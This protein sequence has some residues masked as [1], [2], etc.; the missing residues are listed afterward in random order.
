MTSSS[1]VSDLESTPTAR[2]E[3][4]NFGASCGAGFASRNPRRAFRKSVGEVGEAAKKEDREA[5][6]TGS[7]SSGED[8]PGKSHFV[9]QRGRREAVV[10]QKIRHRT[11]K[12]RAKKVRKNH[13]TEAGSALFVRRGVEGIPSGKE[14]AVIRAQASESRKTTDRRGTRSECPGCT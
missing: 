13:R 1:A 11:H 4:R 2:A 5:D 8:L 12:V 3:K 10:C 9:K 6:R 7:G 14:G